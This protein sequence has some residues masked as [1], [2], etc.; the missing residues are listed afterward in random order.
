MCLKLQ[1][2]V[3]IFFL[4]YQVILDWQNVG[5]A[6]QKVVPASIKPALSRLITYL[7]EVL[8]TGSTLASHNKQKDNPNI[9]TYT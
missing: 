2:I 1:N 5:L 7:F 3:L 4:V 6:S 9:S 8:E